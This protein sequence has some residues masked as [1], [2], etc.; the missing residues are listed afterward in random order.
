[1]WAYF[2]GLF[3]NITVWKYTEKLG[4]DPWS[5]LLT[6]WYAGYVPSFDGT[7][8]RLHAGKDAKVV[9]QWTKEEI[10]AAKN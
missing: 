3:P 4:P 7:T 6:L 2:G 8:W 10:E 1:V 9:A 5:P